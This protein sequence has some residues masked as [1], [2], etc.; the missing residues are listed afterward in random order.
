M[1]GTGMIG[2]TDRDGGTGLRGRMIE[3]RKRC[4]SRRS[5][6]YRCER[7]SLGPHTDRAEACDE[8]HPSFEWTKL[9]A[10]PTSGG[11]RRD[12]IARRR[13]ARRSLDIHITTL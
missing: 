12:V 5:Q 13:D 10:K 8:V 3:K 9:E 11:T 1:G 7:C 2:G 6:C 4:D